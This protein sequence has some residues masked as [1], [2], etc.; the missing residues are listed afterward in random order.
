MQALTDE[1][2]GELERYDR[3]V[4]EL[5]EDLARLKKSRADVVQKRIDVRKSLLAPIRKLPPEIL[6]EIF[7]DVAEPIRLDESV[8]SFGERNKQRRDQS[9]KLLSPVFSLTWVC[10]WWR[11]LVISETRMWSSLNI[12]GCNLS[13]TTPEFVQF[14]RECVQVRA[15]NAPRRF[16]IERPF[17]NNAA[18]RVVPVLDV[19]LESAQQWKDIRFCL[20]HDKSRMLVYITEALRVSGISQWPLLERFNWGIFGLSYSSGIDYPFLQCPRLHRLELPYLCRTDPI[21]TK[22]L[23]FLQLGTYVGASLSELLA[24]CP[25]LDQLKLLDFE[26]E[27]QHELGVPPQVCHHAR[28]S[29]LEIFLHRLTRNESACIWKGLYLPALTSLEAYTEFG[30]G[31]LPQLASMLTRSRCTLR[32]LSA[33]CDITYFKKEEWEAFCTE[34]SSVGQDDFID[35][36]IEDPEDHWEFYI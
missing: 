32:K 18:K 14:M 11:T 1:A 16:D 10:F 31:E 27:S 21:D 17:S 22:H 25:S 3:A 28:L 4:S 30:E 35:I 2:D 26:L 34:I 12:S 36:D 23:T 5:E 13:H 29:R 8:L 19:L 33:K 24:R 20:G 7:N 15:G 6:T 9:G